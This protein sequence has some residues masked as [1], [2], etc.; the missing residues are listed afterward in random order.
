MKIPWIYEEGRMKKLFLLSV[1]IVVT[2]TCCTSKNGK[3]IKDNQNLKLYVD[4]A[5]IKRVSENT[6]RARFTFLYKTPMKVED[7]LL[8][9]GVSYDE[10]DCAQRTY[11]IIEV[12]FYFTDKT[13]A[14]LTEPMEKIKI[15]PDTPAEMEYGYL[16]NAKL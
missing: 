1:I 8:Q 2:L 4:P 6:V 7:K 13:K 10:I 9:K 15:E 5:S 12:T 14:S 16:C 3:L 11:Q